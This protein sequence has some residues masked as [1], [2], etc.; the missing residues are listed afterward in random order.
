MKIQIDI[1]LMI[2]FYKFNRKS[3]TIFFLIHFTS[4]SKQKLKKNV[5][6]KKVQN[7]TSIEAERESN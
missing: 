1:C 3:Y 6:F 2:N 5:M 7:L 4:I